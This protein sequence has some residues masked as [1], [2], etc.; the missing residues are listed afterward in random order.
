MVSG[1]WLAE[2][3]LGGYVNALW[4]IPFLL[5]LLIWA[6][7][8]TWI[9]KDAKAAHLPRSAINIGNLCG[10]VLGALLFFFLPN[11]WIA[12]FLGPVFLFVV[13][14][15]AYLA[16][17]HQKVGLSDLGSQFKKWTADLKARKKRQKEEDAI[18]SGD[19][20]FFIGPGGSIVEPPEAE[21]P[22]RPGYDAVQAF[23]TD[24][25]RKGAERVDMSPGDGMATVKYT[26]DGFAYSAG[27]VDRS[28]AASAVTYLKMIAH[29]DVNDRRKP[30]VGSLKVMVDGQ[31]K[32][33]QIRTAGSAAGEFLT[34]QSDVKHRHDVPLDQ[35]GLLPDQLDL[36]RNAISENAG[37]VLV[38][39]PQG[40][41]LTT[42]LYS[43]LRAHDAFLTHIITV[44]R[45][46]EHDLE[47][48]TQNKLPAKASAAE[49]LKATSWVLSQVPDVVM[50]NSVEDPQ[51]ARELIKYAGDDKR[52]YVGMRA[53]S[54]FDALN[55]WRKLVGD[56]A[57]AMKHL[58]LV[59]CGRVL[60]KLCMACKVGY[61]PDPAT[62]KKLNMDPQRV[63]KLFQARTQPLRDPKGNPIVCEFCQD[64]RFKGRTGVF[65]LMSVD[66]DVREVVTTGGSTSQL[67]AVFRK[68]RGRYLQESGLALVEEGT[69]SVQ[70]VLRVMKVGEG[71]PPAGGARVSPAPR[72]PVRP[73]T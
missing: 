43:I 8:L 67:K 30:Q 58:R 1:N 52:V 26:V 50:I 36:L 9:D 35:S 23:L 53:G 70:E 71:H 16:V 12:F 49:E 48:I 42:M 37:I 27:H 40:Q 39:A 10:L 6:R 24:P 59:I 66:A 2:V 46:A 64:L 22:S 17:R 68:Q 11:F 69:T 65:E 19:S 45:G 62:L 4:A 7:L 13:E 15:T 32:E 47:G 28:A 56:D 63:T 21:S 33:L 73:S 54:A 72:T 44:E 61:A 20:V 18:S 14:V 34:L 25:L 41:G 55:A 38:T 51:T 60:R 31:R 3:T 29:L 57:L 5:L